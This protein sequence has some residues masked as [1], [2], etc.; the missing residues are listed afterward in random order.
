MLDMS[1]KR[2]W[3]WGGDYKD[4]VFVICDQ[5]GKA[6]QRKR[7]SRRWAHDFCDASCEGQFFKAKRSAETQPGEPK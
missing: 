6:F 3:S 2:K 4:L 1:R 7:S 5:C